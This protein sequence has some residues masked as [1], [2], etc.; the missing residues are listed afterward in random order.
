ME[1]ALVEAAVPAAAVEGV[2]GVA[3]A[4]DAA[5]AVH[6]LVDGV[7]LHVALQ[8]GARHVA[9]VGAALALEAL[10]VDH[11]VHRREHRAQRDGARRRR[12]RRLLRLRWRLPSSAWRLLGDAVGG[13]QRGL[14]FAVFVVG[15]GLE[16]G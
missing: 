10:A 2:E 15:L 13:G 5:Q 1:E 3:A 16:R 14:V 9:L 6:A 11:A 12:R 8:R 4:L 7:D